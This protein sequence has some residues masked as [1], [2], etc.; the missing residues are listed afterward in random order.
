MATILEYHLLVSFKK[1]SS[2]PKEFKYPKGKL[3]QI[4]LQRLTKLNGSEPMLQLTTLTLYSSSRPGIYTY[5]PPTNSSEVCDIPLYKVTST[6]AAL[7][8]DPA[9]LVYY[10]GGFGLSE[11]FQEYGPL[12]KNLTSQRLV[13]RLREGGRHFPHR[14][15]QCCALL[16]GY[17]TVCHCNRHGVLSG[18][19]RWPCHRV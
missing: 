15:H 12:N 7:K 3:S 19:S 8:P 1:F 16:R 18:F 17:T 4:S 14:R 10:L 2:K 5:V 13:H 6:P 9:N 11:G